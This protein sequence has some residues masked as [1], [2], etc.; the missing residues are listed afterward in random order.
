[1]SPVNE[2]TLILDPEVQ[3][4]LDDI[5]I[6]DLRIDVVPEITA[7]IEIYSEIPITIDLESIGFDLGGIIPRYGKV[8]RSLLFTKVVSGKK[9][10]YAKSALVITNRIE[11]IGTA[12]TDP[13]NHN[14]VSRFITFNKAISG[15]KTTFGKSTLSIVNNFHTSGIGDIP[16]SDFY[17]DGLYG[18]GLYGTILW[19]STVSLLLGFG[20]SVSGNT[21]SKETSV[22]EISLASH[23]TPST[24]TNHT[25]EIRART[26]SGSTGIIKAALYEGAINRSGDLSTGFLTNSLADYT[27]N[28]SDE[29]ASSI[30][31]YSNLS[32]RLWGYDAL[33]NALVFEVSKLYLKLPVA[34]A[35]GTTHYGALSTNLTFT[36]SVAAV[37]SSL[38]T[39]TAEVSLASH[40]TPSQRTN[41][42]IKIRARTLSGSNGVLRVALYEGAI[43]RSGDLITD[44]LT[45]SL[46]EYT[47]VI[48]DSFAATITNYSNLSIKFFGFDYAGSGLVFEI[49]D[50]RLELPVV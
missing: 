20:S 36:K 22:A 34:S 50:I 43:N 11:V 48:L 1:M 17:G 23:G 40:G 44:P 12:D 10:T 8:G 6:R 37:V 28:I 3:V 2:V 39:E 42:S 35:G 5:P 14:I 9:S 31:N 49:S 21:F 33:G 4:V 32:I 16:N 18:D 13:A 41:H 30:T 27:L 19:Y 7:P 26:T 38:K 45:N 15:K 29:A 25:I 46:A 24:R 47:L